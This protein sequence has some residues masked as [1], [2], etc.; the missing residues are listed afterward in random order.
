MSLAVISAGAVL[1]P[2][3]A[4]AAPPISIVSGPADGSADRRSYETFGL[5]AITAVTKEVEFFC[6]LGG[7]GTFDPCGDKYFP[8]CASNGAIKTCTQLKSWRGL[9]SGSYTFRTFVSECN[10]P[11]DP[12]MSNDDGPE[13]SRRFTVD[14]IDPVVSLLSG[15][16]IASPALSASAKFV[17]T[18]NEPSSF[19]CG[20]DH[21]NLS[22]SGASCTSPIAVGKLK[23]GLHT[24]NVRARDS[25]QNPSPIVSR[26]FRVDFFKPKKC[27]K[28]KSSKGKAKYRACVKSNAR[29]RAK[30][31]KKHR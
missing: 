18:A 20:I 22:W 4:S 15:P 17:F 30:W 7:D 11:C 8:A 2:S 25:V 26:S 24:F 27:K 6:T 3:T 21:T 5:S 10:S 13:S 9:V 12:G 29:A 23:N 31:K 19:F 28:A 14:L 16:S 1:S